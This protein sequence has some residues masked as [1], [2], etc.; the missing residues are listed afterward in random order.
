MGCTSSH[1]RFV[2]T[3]ENSTKKT[4][5]HLANYKA[6]RA[7]ISSQ[8]SELKQKPY[9]LQT[10]HEPPLTIKNNQDYISLYKRHSGELRLVVVLE[11]AKRYK[12]ELF[13]TI[14][15]SIFK[16]RKGKEDIEATGFMLSPRMCLIGI[17]ENIYEYHA[18]FEDGTSLNFKPD[19]ILISIGSFSL[20][21]LELTSKWVS[22][23]IQNKP[24]TMESDCADN[25]AV[26]FYYS[27]TRPVL[28]EYLGQFTKSSK[29]SRIAFEPKPLTYCTPGAPVFNEKGKIFAV[30]L[31][32][33][34]ALRVEKIVRK[35]ED[36]TDTMSRSYQEAVE[37][38]LALSSVQY[39]HGS[40]S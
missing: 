38:S 40:N 34:K 8:F 28:Q 18:L 29:N 35:L 37:E 1:C 5:Q 6:A 32:K 25:Q 12:P 31:G 16:V 23:T 33:G 36:E 3:F 9:R 4:E 2:V 20:V 19:G 24:L 22:K 13:S 10:Q 14:S 15:N 27:T 39:S 21:E 17:S 7:W 30:Y 26:I 11:K